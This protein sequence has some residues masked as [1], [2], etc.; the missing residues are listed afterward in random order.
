[1]LIG[2]G[3]RIRP[4]ALDD[5]E[6]VYEQVIDVE[7]RG[8]WYPLP[9]RSFVAFRRAFEEHGYWTLDS[10]WFL[11]EDKAG[12]VVGQIDWARLSGDIPDME[13]GYRTYL[14]ADRGK[15]YVTEAVRLMTRWLF[16]TQP[17]NRIRLTAHVDNQASRHVAVKCG[18][19]HEATAHEAWP[20]R[21]RWH[22][23]DVFIQ[24]RSAFAALT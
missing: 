11:I 9:T 6:W 23:V 10:G 13:L 16:E 22:D 24:T 18:F 2:E 8:P 3:V 5:L 14:Q 4:I 15:G 19:T 21:G 1:M 7:S 12:R 20:S 17:I